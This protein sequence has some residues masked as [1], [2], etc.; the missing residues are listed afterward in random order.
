LNFQELREIFQK[1][2]VAQK[3]AASDDDHPGKRKPID[4][5]CPICF[6]EFEENEEIVWCKAACGNNIHAACFERWASIQQAKG[7]TCVYW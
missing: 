1:A 2:P 4:G 7:V 3:E 5:D 6:T